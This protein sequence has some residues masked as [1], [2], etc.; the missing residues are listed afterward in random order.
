VNTVRTS[1]RRTGKYRILIVDDH[2]VIQRGLAYAL[3][4]EL[5]MEVCG[6][7]VSVAGALTAMEESRPDLVVVDITLEDSSG[8][9]LIAEIKN[10][11]A[12]VRTVV[13]SSFDEK[14]FAERAIRAG[15]MGYV[16]KKEP[17]ERLV[18]AIRQVL[19][20]NFYLSAG[21]TNRLLQRASGS[22]PLEEDP[23]RRL[24]NRELEVF[25]MIGQGMT[26]KQ[27]A[28]KLDLSPKT[29]EAHREN[30]KTKL[31]LKNS[32]ELNRRAVLW[33]LENS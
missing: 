10:R 15:A 9:E 4:Q 29:V 31:D 3:S 12:D 5:D 6:G 23:I 11:K 24:S 16:N 28:R 8:L 7:A 13:W 20:G 32:G 17:I 19:G 30:I 25:T 2:P 18:S 26:T 33:V 27:I 14:I 1:M 22:R 21:M